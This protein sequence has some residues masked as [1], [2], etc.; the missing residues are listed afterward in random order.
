MHPQPTAFL[1][2]DIPDQPH[3]LDCA[4]CVIETFLHLKDLEVLLITL[5]MVMVLFSL[6]GSRWFSFAKV[7]HGLLIF[8]QGSQQ[9]LSGAPHD[10]RLAPRCVLL[11]LLLSR[12]MI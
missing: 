11:L 4:H 1:L 2:L 6:L 5:L 8:G 3:L 12:L 10:D 9:L 7:R